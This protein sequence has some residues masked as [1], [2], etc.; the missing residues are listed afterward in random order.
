MGGGETGERELGR[1]LREERNEDGIAG[2]DWALV[3]LTLGSAPERT[4][5]T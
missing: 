1:R 5:L 3:I 4:A 2:N